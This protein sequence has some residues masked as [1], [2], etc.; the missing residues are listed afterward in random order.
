M[1]REANA[2]ATQ[3]SFLYCKHLNYIHQG[4]NISQIFVAM[5][6]NV[7]PVV[8]KVNVLIAQKNSLRVHNHKWN[9]LKI[10]CQRKSLIHAVFNF[11][12]FGYHSNTDTKIRKTPS[13]SIGALGFALCVKKIY[14]WKGCNQIQFELPIITSLKTLHRFYALSPSIILVKILSYLF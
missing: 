1:E 11:F 6:S 2:F 4:Y 13:L 9:F 5:H 12:Q 10:S 7:N 8:L 14:C 3:S